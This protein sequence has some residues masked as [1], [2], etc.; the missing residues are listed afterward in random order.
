MGGTALQAKYGFVGRRISASEFKQTIL[1]LQQ[2]AG[3]QGFDVVGVRPYKRKE[4]HGDIDIA[5]FS[6]YARPE[7]PW[8]T[9]IKS[10]FGAKFVSKNSFVYS[11]DYNGIQIDLAVFDTE[12]KF[13]NYL[14]FCD[15][16]PFGNLYGK[17][18]KQVGLTWGMNGLVYKVKDGTQVIGEIPIQNP[19]VLRDFTNMLSFGGLKLSDYAEFD[20]QTDIFDFVLKSRLFNRDIFA[21]ENLNNEGRNRDSKRAD[22]VEWL[23]YIKDKP[24]VFIEVEDKSTYFDEIC[25]HFKIDL[26][27]KIN[28]IVARH[29]WDKSISQRFNGHIINKITGHTGTKLGAF[30]SRFKLKYSELNGEKWKLW[31]SRHSDGQI[32]EEIR[33]F[34]ETF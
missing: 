18:L 33:K 23:D 28:D 13:H 19:G 29:E 16:S 11:F 10:T 24:N 17:L 12:R 4:T 7:T 3:L 1:E 5:T 8:P 14:Y 27:S 2:K 34:N 30:I 22:Y 32:E 15:Y 20:K 31:V 26:Y 25:N 9:I 6:D 21:L